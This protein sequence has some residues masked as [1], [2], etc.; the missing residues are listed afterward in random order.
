M[1]EK[2][3]NDEGIFSRWSKRKLDKQANNQPDE[4]LMKVEHSETNEPK[5][6]DELAL[7]VWLQDD[8]DPDVKRAAL[9]NLFREPEFNVVDRM[10]EYDE[11]FTQF[12]SLGG[13]VT[14]Q[15][16]HMFKLAEQKTRP[17]EETVKPDVNT[18]ADTEA[19]SSNEQAIQI[20]ESKN[21]NED[22]EIA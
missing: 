10:N 22:N 9:S 17:D 2:P 14:Q 5:S 15:M 8:A 12:T 4:L 3:E 19:A 20:N 21:D 7:P 13:I 11:D 6:E 18:V 1:T 16:K